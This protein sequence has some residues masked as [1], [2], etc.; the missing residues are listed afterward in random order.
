MSQQATYRAEIHELY[1]EITHMRDKSE[2]QAALSAKMCRVESP[3]LSVE[4][5]PENVLHTACP[6]R[7]PSW[8]LLTS[9]IDDTT[10]RGRQRSM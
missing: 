8:I 7:S 6:S 9:R 5:E 2:L 10:R 4:A 1:T 3:S